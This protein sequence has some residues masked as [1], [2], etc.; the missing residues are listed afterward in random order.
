MSKAKKKSVKQ[1]SSKLSL[2]NLKATDEERHIFEKAA[3]RYTKG[4][5]SAWLRLAGRRF[6]PTKTD[7]AA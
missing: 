6:R 3:K 1:K 5:V 4:N 7:L 2:L